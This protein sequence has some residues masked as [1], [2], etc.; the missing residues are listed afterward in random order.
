MRGRPRDSLV[1][2]ISPSWRTTQENCTN[3]YLMPFHPWRTFMASVQSG[4]FLPTSFREHWSTAGMKCTP[5]LLVISQKT[6]WPLCS[7]RGIWL[8]ISPDAVQRNFWWIPRTEFPSA[9]LQHLTQHAVS[10]LR[11]FM[12]ET[13][14][15]IGGIWMNSDD[16]NSLEVWAGNI[17]KCDEVEGETEVRRIYAICSTNVT[18]D[19][20][21]S[22]HYHYP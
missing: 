6:T 10:R 13:M 9:I 15:S 4:T 5:S 20:F 1:C 12:L 7:S 3:S 11:P 2:I 8:L 22:C 14:T 18:V 17:F 19:P 21:G 16:V